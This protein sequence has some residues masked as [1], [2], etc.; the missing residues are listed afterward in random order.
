MSTKHILTAC[1]ASSMIAAHA[2]VDITIDANNL[3]PKI[4]PTHY[5]IF[6]EDINHAA[7]GG[8]YAE[9]IQNRSFEDNDIT[10]VHW[11]AVHNQNSRA[12]IELTAEDPMNGAH[13]KSLR[14]IV[15]KA[16]GRDMAGVSN[17]G[18]WGM[19]VVKGREYRL[20]FRCTP[21]RCKLLVV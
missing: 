6:F 9:L 16:G 8:L 3:G 1:L 15:S 13:N 10:P 21:Y 20:S 14:V 2:Q 12:S 4:S 5:G 11:K 17:S 18:Y 19:N 7:D